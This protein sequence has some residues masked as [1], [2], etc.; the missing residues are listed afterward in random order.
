MSELCVETKQQTYMQI[1]AKWPGF[2]I[3]KQSIAIGQKMFHL[4]ATIIPLSR[5]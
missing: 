5:V 2:G 1:P 4:C 3:W